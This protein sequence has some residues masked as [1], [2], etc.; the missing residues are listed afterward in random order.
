M[1]SKKYN[2]LYIKKKN[3]N[4]ILT[5]PS[6]QFLN[7]KQFLCKTY[8]GFCLNKICVQKSFWLFVIM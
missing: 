6:K 4:K 7:I 1:C 3:K 8:K 5:K 2:V